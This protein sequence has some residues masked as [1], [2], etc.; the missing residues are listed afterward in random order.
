MKLKTHEIF[1]YYGKSQLVPDNQG[2]T[3]PTIGSV[4]LHPCICGCQERVTP[5]EARSQSKIIEPY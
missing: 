2:K 5:I 3:V 1:A 4:H